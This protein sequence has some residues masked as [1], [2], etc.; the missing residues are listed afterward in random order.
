[1]LINQ[2]LKKNIFIGDC[3]VASL[4]YL[5]NVDGLRAIAVIAVIFAHLN[6]SLHKFGIP[7]F[8]SGGYV[9][10]DIFF[11]I[12]G[13][14]IT[15][16]I[17]KEINNTG[18]FS[19]VNFYTRRTRRIL[20]ALTFV[21]VLT[22]ILSIWL[23]N[24]SKFKVFGGSLAT[25]IISFSN[26][27]FYK[28]S[29]YF[30]IYSQSNPLLHT[31]SLGVEEQFY[32]FWPIILLIA[33]NCYFKFKNKSKQLVIPFII[34]VF[35]ISL[36]WSIHRQNSDLNSLYFLAPFR[37][38][39]FCIGGSLVWLLKFKSDKNT[40][41]EILCVIGF[42][43]VF[44]TILTYN[45]N[46]LFPSYNVLPPTIGAA[47]LIYAGSAKFSGYILRNRA[48]GFV[49]LISYSLYLIH[50]PI[51]VFIKTYNEDVGGAFAMSA[52]AKLV[53][54]ILSVI[55]AIAMYYFIEQPFRKNIPKDGLKQ[56]KILIRWSILVICIVALGTSIFYSKGWIWREN[57]P[58]AAASIEDISNYHK[59]NWGGSGFSGGMIY[60][61]KTNYR[62]IVM[63]G[64]S[65]SGMLDTGMVNEIAK[66]KDISIFT[67]SGGGAG[68]YD[69]SLLLPGITRI[70]A[71]QTSQDVS[72][73]RANEQIKIELS[74]FKYKNLIVIYSASYSSQ[75]NMAGYLDT[76]KKLGI[77]TETMNKYTQYKPF[78]DSLERLQ[79]EIG[80]HPLILIGDV[81]GASK[82]NI[83]SCLSAIKW[84]NQ[85]GTCL[86]A[87]KESISVAAINV[88]TILKEY[89]KK[90]KNV[91]FINPFDTFCKNRVCKNLSK[92][93]TP[94]YSDG[95]HLSKTGSIYFIGHVKNKILTIIN[96]KGSVND[97][98]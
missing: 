53:A 76:H 34:A 91:Y 24:L 62:N 29:G 13:F 58:T 48:V 45:S 55:I 19:F 61:G 97:V 37:A 8:F 83:I 75:I 44:Y 96:E 81:P 4:K 47:L 50:W 52:K 5:K 71:S 43:L 23:L 40:I 65:H 85:V 1:M 72:S 12:S 21:L 2:S 73:K 86:T 67:I 93:G 70:A 11:V 84:F 87:Q 46:T 77:N 7:L 18:S 49:G 90:H 32:I 26:F 82:Y 33:S 35:I 14:L 79:K 59:E 15:N 60:Q 95:N 41:N 6:I 56:K 63:M 10:V 94:F 9:G 31:W 78:T 74:K 54:L 98:I 16:I 68:S 27:F 25:S 57:S 64:D 51:I 38:F 39:E 28:Q 36:A 80:S 30:D 69:S 42:T 20:P 66:P 92:N 88:N 3:S 17:M 89:A 22:F